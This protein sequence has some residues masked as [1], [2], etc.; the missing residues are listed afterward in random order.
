[1]IYCDTSFLT[2]L[3][4]DGDAFHSTARREAARFTEAIPYTNL[5][6]LEFRN[7]LHRSLG[8]GSLDSSGHDAIVRDVNRD[9][10]DGLIERVT[11]NQIKLYERALMLSRKHTPAIGCRSLDIL[12]VAAAVVLG[13]S[14]FASFDE[15]Q[16][17][18]AHTVGLTLIPSVLR[19]S[20]AS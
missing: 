8:D 12:H 3:Y 14:K 18:L 10:A 6:E 16:R 1:M 13:A 4:V 7:A 2:S 15:R 5:S 20:S 11:L 17:R 9:E 19:K